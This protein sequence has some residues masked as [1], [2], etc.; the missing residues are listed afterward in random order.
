MLDRAKRRVA[1]RIL[2]AKALPE[3]TVPSKWGSIH[4][5]QHC[6]EE[7]ESKLQQES[8]EQIEELLANEACWAQ[9]CTLVIE[10]PVN[11]AN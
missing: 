9:Q 4:K 7:R 10:L 11:E 6:L 8:A 1:R 5:N 2:G 3:R